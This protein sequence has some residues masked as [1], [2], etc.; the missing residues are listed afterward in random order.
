MEEDQYRLMAAIQDHHWW[1]EAKRQLVNSLLESRLGQ[2]KGGRVLEVGCGPGPM[3]PALRRWGS[4]V[5][6]DYHGPALAYVEGA[7]RVVSD[8]RHLPFADR[9][10]DLIG[11]FDL[12]YHRNV[13]EV[14]SA[15]A[16]IHRVCDVGGHLVITDSACKALYSAHDLAQH[17]ARRFGRKEL[18]EMLE[19]AGF[20][21][22]HSSYFHTTLFPLAAAW[23]LLTRWLRGAPVAS[24][25]DEVGQEA[26]GHSDLGEVPRWLNSA[27][28]RF[29]KLETKLAARTS[30]PFGLSLVI[31]ARRS[32]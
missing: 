20:E 14:D 1:F 11:S 22:L 12:L 28:I 8:V 10:F 24:D 26:S 21:S 25:A 17:G 13:P 16:E 32:A 27:L 23:R 7:H 19:A 18:V 29:Y 4:V 31:L 2:S 3:V 9:T 6:V 15:I 30:L 5:G